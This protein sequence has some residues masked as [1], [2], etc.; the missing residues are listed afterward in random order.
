MNA[1][2]DYIRHAIEHEQYANAL[3]QWNHYARQLRQAVESGILPAEQMEE[4]RALYQWAR[5]VLLSAQA[6]LRYR[7]HELEV[8]AAYNAAR[9]AAAPDREA[10]RAIRA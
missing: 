3:A 4:A 1:S 6:H 7:Y 5:P 10:P 9:R 8:A 2:A